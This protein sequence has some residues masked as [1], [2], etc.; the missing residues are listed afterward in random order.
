MFPK[1]SPLP[2][3]P[4]QNVTSYDTAVLRP[5]VIPHNQHSD[6]LIPL[7]HALLFL[8][9]PTWDWS[10]VSE[11][12]LFS[13]CRTVPRLGFL[14]TFSIQKATNS[15][16]CSW[17]TSQLWLY[18]K[19]LPPKAAGRCSPKIHRYLSGFI[20]WS[21]KAFFPLYFAVYVVQGVWKHYIS[22][23]QTG[24]MWLPKKSQRLGQQ[25]CA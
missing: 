11:G 8:P 14:Q 5:F 13:I 21:P 17:K 25:L 16:H 9:P 6:L 23:L 10:L 20:C 7:C 2:G 24:K 3:I 19:P 4:P 12:L 18:I 15:Y 22:M 1:S